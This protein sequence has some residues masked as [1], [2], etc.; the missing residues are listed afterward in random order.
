MAPGDLNE[1]LDKLILV[2]G[3]W[4]ISC[5]IALRSMSLDLTDYK[6]LVEQICLGAAVKQQAI[7]QMLTKFCDAIWHD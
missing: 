6:P 3:G 2:I 4:G 5:E 1:M 7:K